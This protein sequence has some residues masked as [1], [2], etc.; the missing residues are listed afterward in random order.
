MEVFHISPEALGALEEV[1]RRYAVTEL[2]VFGSAVRGELTPES[3][4]DLLVTFVEGALVT[5]STLAR[6]QREAEE[7]LGRSVD[8]VPR[9]GLKEEIRAQVIASS[10]VLY[11]A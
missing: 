8:V 7:I 10:R 4:L 9:S 2:A 1:C 6:F 11:A 3:D 5:F